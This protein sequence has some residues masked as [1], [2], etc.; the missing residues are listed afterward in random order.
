MR[1]FLKIKGILIFTIVCFVSSGC[2][3]SRI[4]VVEKPKELA[5]VES[6]KP[7]IQPAPQNSPIQKFDFENF[8]FPEPD[9]GY[10]SREKGIRYWGASG[11]H[12]RLTDGEEPE[13][14]GKDGML[15]NS[16][17]SL[18]SVEYAEITGDNEQ[19]ALVRLS[20]L[21]GGS[22]MANNFYI[23]SWQKQKPKLIFS[24]SDG[25]RADGGFRS[26]YAENG[27]LII[28]LIAGDENAPD[29]DGCQSTR[30]LRL[31]YKWNGRKFVKV[32]QELFSIK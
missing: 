9:Y 12:Y 5:V 10:L 20:I 24:F 22:A 16:P 6:P 7:E 8:T 11:D 17:A 2:E 25:D 21:T 23:Y 19:E 18:S 31:R 13:I 28:E 26:M 32:N 1:V 27:D 15:K 3:K 29:C 4:L 14:R 30:F